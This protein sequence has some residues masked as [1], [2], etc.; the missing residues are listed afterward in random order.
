[1][2]PLKH[3]DIESLILHPFQYLEDGT[4]HGNIDGLFDG[5]SLDQE[6]G[7]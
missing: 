6:D 5:I 2:E 3:L 7:V 1:M 4:A